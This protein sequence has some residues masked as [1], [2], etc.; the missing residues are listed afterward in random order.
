[1]AQASHRPGI[2]PPLVGGGTGHLPGLYELRG[3]QQPAAL[4]RHADPDAEDVGG[5]G[6]GRAGRLTRRADPS[7][8]AAPGTAAGW[9]PVS[10]TLKVIDSK[11]GSTRPCSPRPATAR[12]DEDTSQVCN[13]SMAPDSSGRDPVSG[14]RIQREER[15][16]GILLRHPPGGLHGR[17]VG[18]VCAGSLRRPEIRAGRIWSGATAGLCRLGKHGRGG[19]APNLYLIDLRDSSSAR[20]ATGTWLA[21]PALWLGDPADS[22]PTAGLSLDSLGHYNEPATGYQP[23]VFSEKM[24]LFWNRHQERGGDLH[25]QLP[26]LQRHRSP[27]GHRPPG[28]EHRLSPRM[29]GWARRNGWR[30]MPSTIARSSRCW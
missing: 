12:P 9:P 17:S 18:R 3:R 29:A 25:R 19:P 22:I 5:Q 7:M 30:A 27:Q 2:H 4:V 10:G 8:T 20:L 15:H 26:C 1:M 24:S 16:H 11:A 28:P 6:A 13:V 14:L 21:T 23:A